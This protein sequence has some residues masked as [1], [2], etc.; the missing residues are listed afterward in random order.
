MQP[1]VIILDMANGYHWTPGSYGYEL[2]ARI[3]RLK[4][5][6]HAAGVPHGLYHVV[7]ELLK[8]AVYLGDPSRLLSQD[9]VGQCAHIQNGQG[10]SPGPSP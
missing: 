3:R 2:V 9:G 1:A 7:N 5:A 10:L 6:A 4:D 8:G